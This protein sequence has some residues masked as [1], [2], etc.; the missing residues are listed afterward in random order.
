MTKNE[1]RRRGRPSAFDRDAALDQLMLLFWEKGFDAT[2]QSDMMRRTGLSSSSLYNA[3]GTKEATFERALVRYNEM[4]D[5]G[6]AQV[7]A[8]PTGLGA[9]HAFVAARQAT[10]SNPALGPGCLVTT[11]MCELGARD[12]A[13]HTH[14]A[15]HLDLLRQ[16]V[17]AAIERGVAE[18]ELHPGDTK[19]R[20]ALLVA[21]HVGSAATERSAG[22]QRALEMVQGMRTL[23]E[24]WRG[25]A[26][27][28]A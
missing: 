18:G 10:V 19:T 17:E 2:T 9:L 3:F 8:A 12:G 28:S 7:L 23:V 22:A 14:C 27:Q 15:R 21:A 6:L 1:P 5:A 16:T 11:T 24:S 25:P 4:A 26:P 20:A 13:H